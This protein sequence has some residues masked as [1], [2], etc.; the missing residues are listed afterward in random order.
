MARRAV[1]KRSGSRASRWDV[2]NRPQSNPIVVFD[3]CDT[4]SGKHATHF[5]GD[6]RGALT[7]ADY[8]GYK[9]V[10][11][12]RYEIPHPLLSLALAANQADRT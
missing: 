5:L 3:I 6:Y 4:R 7:V 12:T 1:Y 10:T 8:A 11:V 9:G 2:P